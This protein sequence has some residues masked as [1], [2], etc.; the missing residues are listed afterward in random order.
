MIL[1]VFFF[2]GK[3][4]VVMGCDIGLGQGM[5]LGLVEVGCDIVGINIVELMEII[6][7]V[8]VLGCCFLSLIVDLC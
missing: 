8:I 6:V 4:V 2:E 3:V 5:V 7:C 1:N